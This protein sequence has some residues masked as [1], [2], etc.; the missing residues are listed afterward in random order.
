[1]RGAWRK[2]DPLKTRPFL[3]VGFIAACLLVLAWRGTLSTFGQDAPDVIYNSPVGQFTLPTVNATAGVLGT[4]YQLAAFFFG[5][6]NLE[7][8]V[9]DLNGNTGNGFSDR[10]DFENLN[11]FSL[12]QAGSQIGDLDSLDPANAV[13]GPGG[14]P[15]NPGFRFVH[16]TLRPHIWLIGQETNNQRAQKVIVFP[17][18]DHLFDPEVPGYGPNAMNPP[19]GGLG[20]AVLEAVEFTV[21]G[22]DDRNEAIAAAQIPNFFGVGGRGILPANGKWVRGVLIKIFAEGF[23]DYNGFSPFAN[24]PEGTSP[25]PQEGDDFASCWE[26]RDQNGNPATAKY[27]AI[28]AN[29]TR[30][31]RFFIPDASNNIPGNLAESTDAEIDAVGFVPFV[32]PGP[33]PGKCVTLCFR[34]P[35][36]YLLNIKRLPRGTVV[37]GGVNFNKPI[38]TSDT[39]AIQMALQ[40]SNPLGKMNP[41]PLQRL[42]RE[43]VAAQLSLAAAGGATTPNVVN[44]LWGTLRCSG[45]EFAPITLGNGATLSPDSML[46]ELF[47]NAQF[48]IQENRTAD[49][50]VLAALFAEING[51][52]PFGKCG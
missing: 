28:F 50:L 34:S 52:D 32:G 26:F 31:I 19:P 10:Y 18:V 16:P 51:N 11:A 42:N 9:A 48:A 13:P 7:P 12:G 8:P 27:V 20:N 39:A 15:I 21:W 1:M 41:S 47:M 44:A 2:E 46:K 6:P 3:I 49:M 38:S 37:I 4:D 40:G 5:I 23:K 25:S 33:S 43:Y 24:L 35:Q 45:L 29:R 14:R 36:Y 22:T 30:D 17:S